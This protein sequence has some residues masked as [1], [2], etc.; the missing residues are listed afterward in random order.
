MRTLILSDIHA[1]LEAL[2]AALEQTAF[3]AVWVLGD[4]VGYGAD[5]HAVVEKVQELHPQFIIRGNHDKVCSGLE[6]AKD[7]SLLAR[8]SAEWTL[9]TLSPETRAYLQA[10]PLGPVPFEDYLLCHGSPA[11]E[12]EY[13]MSPYQIP[14]LLETQNAQVCF[15][16]HT[17]VPIIY[18]SDGG[19]IVECPVGESLVLQLKEGQ[20]YFLNPGSVGQPRDGD[21]RGCTALLDTHRKVVEF[22]KFDY[23]IDEAARKI[24]EAGLPRP[25]AE[26]LYVGR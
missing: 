2:K 12:D 19:Q 8:Q 18:M 21:R 23:A 7:F 9:R 14:A 25:L 16:G 20:R 15:F 24:R 4:L 3:D 10:L 6:S 5:P 11:D 22:M 17:H 1:N 26:R 13:I